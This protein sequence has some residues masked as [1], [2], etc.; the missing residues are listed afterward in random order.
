MEKKKCNRR[1]A[2]LAGGVTGQGATEGGENVEY[3]AIRTGKS[4]GERDSRR[5][6]LETPRK[7]NAAR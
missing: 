3:R 7:T 6:E 5:V 4:G 1:A 2:E